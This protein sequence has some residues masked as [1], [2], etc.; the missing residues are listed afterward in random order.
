M[1]AELLGKG[2]IRGR[3]TMV[4]NVLNV[5]KGEVHN[6]AAY[7]EDGDP[8]VLLQTDSIIY[9]RYVDAQFNWRWQVSFPVTNA[10]G[11]SVVY[12]VYWTRER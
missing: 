2:F 12:E 4:W 1:A 8:L 5:P 7:P 11:G 9:L 10:S 6:F 3:S